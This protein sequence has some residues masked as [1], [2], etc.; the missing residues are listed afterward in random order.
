MQ[1]A[2]HKIHVW[3]KGEIGSHPSFQHLRRGGG[4]QQCKSDNRALFHQDLPKL[5]NTSNE[6]SG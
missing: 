3:L 1:L 2:R 5:Q 4:G 6:K